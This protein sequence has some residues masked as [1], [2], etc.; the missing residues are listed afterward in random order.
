MSA[1]QRR[2]GAVVPWDFRASGRMAR[3]H[4]R[5]LELAF[6]T[7]ARQ[8][9]TQMV[10]RL[11]ADVAV[12]LRAVEQT[13]YDEHASTLSV[14]SPLV[15]IGTDIGAAGLLHVPAE[16]VLSVVDHGLGGPGR[17]QEARELTEL[18]VGVLRDLGDKAM[19]ALD[20][21][22]ATITPLGARRTATEQIP[23]LAQAAQASDQVVVAH[24]TVTVGATTG[25]ATLALVLAPLQARLGSSTAPARSAEE[26]EAEARAQA[27][28]VGAMPRVPVEVALR[29]TPTRVTSDRVLDLAV[30]D[31][32]PLG[33]PTS[34]PLEVVVAGLVVARA[35]PTASS[36]RLACMV[37]ST[38]E[39]PR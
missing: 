35:V 22:F 31:V 21:A 27:A 12:E 23:Q 34:R 20:Y 17:Q 33:H 32:V 3:E 29:L 2:R 37:V 36:T 13:T 30:G 16:V 39:N 11:R 19:A 28:V 8:W 25:E 7:L 18:E 14:P 6:E 38:E 15:V 5:V 1:R 4:L 26:L 10:T 9:T 24:L